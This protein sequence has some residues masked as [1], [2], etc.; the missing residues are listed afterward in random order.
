MEI[1]LM[2]TMLRKIGDGDWLYHAKGPTI[3]KMTIFAAGGS[4]YRF[5]GPNAYDEKPKGITGNP[6]KTLLVELSDGTK[7]IGTIGYR[8]LTNEVLGS[9]KAL[10]GKD[11]FSFYQWEGEQIVGL[12][13]SVA[14][15]FLN[16]NYAWVES[17]ILDA[18]G[19]VKGVP[20]W[21]MMGQSAR[22][23]IDPYDGT[24]YF[25]DIAHNTD[26]RIIAT[27]GKRIKQDG[28]RAVKLKIGRPDKWLPGEAGVERD[29]ESFI[30]LREAVG[31][32]FN[33]MAD[34]NNGYRNKFEWAIKMLKA[35]APYKMYFIEEL[36]PDD[37]VAYGVLKE[38]LLQENAVIPIADGESIWQEDMLE[39]F[40]DY[41]QAGVY[42]YIQ[43]D[44]PTCGFSSILRVSRMAAQYPSVKLIPHVWQSQM[45]MLMSAHISKIQS[46]IPFIE[47]SRYMEHVLMTPGYE[48]VQGQWHI[49][50]QPGWG[51]EL[52]PNYEQFIV[53]EKMVVE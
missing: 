39:V 28:Y 47:D 48:F 12:E 20:V 24:L 21:Q 2:G 44:M 38:K 10:I 29:I 31:H 42:D 5:I 3:K 35:C 6:R 7:G 4:F 52:I 30:A 50:N 46:N 18:L 37:Q 53:G 13:P 15:Y 40:Q 9:V 22:Q 27:L 32:N 25:A 8:P 26:A 14:E 11:I 33:I 17:G 36:F 45:G 16:A 34:A 43:P 19:R 23:G 1:G 41:C 51:V 49:P